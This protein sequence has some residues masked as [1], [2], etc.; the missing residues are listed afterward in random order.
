M[1]TTS[2]LHDLSPELALV[3]ERAAVDARAA[4]SDPSVTLDRIL[5]EASASAREVRAARQRIIELSD[6]EPP[7][8]RRTYRRPKLVGAFATWA[9]V[10]VLVAESRIHTLF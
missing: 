1:K 7:Q 6:V 9:V 2:P 10:A 8:R 5:V 3:D 4:L